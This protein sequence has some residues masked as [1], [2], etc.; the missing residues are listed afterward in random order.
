MRDR[1]LFICQATVPIF[2]ILLTAVSCSKPDMPPQPAGIFEPWFSAPVTDT[3]N[4]PLVQS[5]EGQPKVQRARPKTSQP[6]V[7]A[8]V[9]TP[10]PTAKSASRLAPKKASAAPRTGAQTE[11]QLFEEFLEWR[12]RQ[13]LP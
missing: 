1:L 9:H 3:A 13:G 4:T 2:V 7:A 12:K 10:K 5:V 11:R 8:V 6:R